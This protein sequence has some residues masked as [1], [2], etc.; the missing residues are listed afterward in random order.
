M[1]LGV[2]LA[3]PGGAAAHAEL[4]GSNPAANSTLLEAPDSLTLSFSEEIDPGTIRVRL[5]DAQQRE[6]A[7]LG[8]PAVGADGVTVTAAL[9]ALEDGVYTVDYQV[10]SA[11]DGHITS[12]IFAFG[13]DPTG[14]QPVPGVSS[15]SESPAP[16][17]PSAPASGLA[18]SSR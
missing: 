10:T 1:A 8:P 6:T 12:G 18:A 16:P 2:A 14:T 11:V 7:G 17:A 3:A 15:Q 4:V 13:V 9:P 5:L